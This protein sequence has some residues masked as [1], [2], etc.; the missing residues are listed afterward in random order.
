MKF[1]PEVIEFQLAHQERSKTKA[2]YNH[3]E[4]LEE[5]RDMMQRWADYLDA[6]AA[7]AKVTPIR[8]AT[9]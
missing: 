3:A 4:Y 9:A 6:V 5:R 2:S 1:R 8:R 7:G